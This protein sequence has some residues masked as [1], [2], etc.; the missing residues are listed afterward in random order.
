MAD[1]QR[2]AIGEQRIRCPRGSPHALF[3]GISFNQRHLLRLT[4]RFLQIGDGFG[5]D[6]EE[7]TILKELSDEA[8]DVMVAYCE[9]RPSPLCHMVIEELGGAVSRAAQEETAFN[10]RNMRYNFLSAGAWTDPSQDAQ[11]TRWARE[12]WQAMQTFSSGGVYVNYLGQ[13]ADEGADRVKAA[14]G[15]EKYERLVS[16]GFNLPGSSSK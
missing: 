16:K 14:Y 9:N 13:E 1:I 5:V 15:P 3:A 11:C 8:I 2:Q 6:R 7:P 4:R 10:H 12:F